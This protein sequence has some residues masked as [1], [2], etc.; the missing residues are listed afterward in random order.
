MINNKPLIDYV[1]FKTHKSPVLLF[2]KFI[3]I[4][5]VLDI[6][7]III[8]YCAE[9]V[10][11]TITNISLSALLVYLSIY[12]IILIYWFIYWFLDY[13]KIESWKIIHTRGV[14]LRR[15]NIYT[16]NEINTVKLKQS[17]LWR[18]FDYSNIEIWYNNKKIIFRFVNYPDEFIHIIDIFK[19]YDKK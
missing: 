11:V 3:F 5:I 16:I 12:L 15:K 2:L 1:L 19:T 18:I 9:L 7:L 8:L 10:N 14:I 13:Y 17:F 6:I 4:I